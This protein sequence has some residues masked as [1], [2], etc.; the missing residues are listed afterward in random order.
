[1]NQVFYKCIT[2]LFLIFPVIAN[3]QVTIGSGIPSVKGALLDLKEHVPD[4]AGITATKG[5][6]LP[7]VNLASSTS[8]APVTG[9]VNELVGLVVYNVNTIS[10]ERFCP[11]PYV[12]IGTEW[13][14]L[15]LSTAGMLTDVEGNT[16]RT[17]TFGSAG[18]WMIENL[19]T[20]TYAD[21][22]T[23]PLL[24]DGT[25]I[26]T[27]SKY[28]IRP[29][30]SPSIE[31]PGYGLLYTW[32]AATNDTYSDFFDNPGAGT[33]KSTVQ[34][35]CPA[36]WVVPS[37]YDW[38][39]L[40]KEIANNSTTY[41]T[42]TAQAW[43]PTWETAYNTDPRGD[44]GISMKSSVSVDS[45]ATDGQSFSVC[46]NNGFN[47]LMVGGVNDSNT[48]QVYTSDNYGSRAYFWTSSQ[49]NS[50]G[51]FKWYRR[52]YANQSDGGVERHFH[53]ANQYIYSVRCKKAD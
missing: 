34:G 18:T 28:Y 7:R 30:A 39:L 22:T 10:D 9:D 3:S 45:V 37:D 2:I 31:K 44:F 36:G 17:A 25:S 27:D 8:L 50:G 49:Q 46:R 5:L 32:A 6:A 53:V 16:Y 21:G 15:V 26:S 29:N 43:D 11:G 33:V 13:T 1:M 35:I 20:K 41:S 4:A 38:T 52:F 23:L 48:D 14:P 40:E 12:W 24:Q 47:V 51:I 19:R 42:Y